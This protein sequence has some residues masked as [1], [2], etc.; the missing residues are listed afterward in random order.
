MANDTRD[1]IAPLVFR[2]GRGPW[3]MQVPVADKGIKEVVLPMALQAYYDERL[4]T[5]PR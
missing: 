2:V 3:K 5:C 1:L 4:L